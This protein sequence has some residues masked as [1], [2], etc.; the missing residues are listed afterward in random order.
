MIG[1]LGLFNQVSEIMTSGTFLAG[2]DNLVAILR[3]K[4]LYKRSKTS[5]ILRATL[6]R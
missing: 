4:Y 3:F 1:L 6:H 5:V 2:D